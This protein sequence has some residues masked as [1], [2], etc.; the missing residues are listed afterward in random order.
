MK[1]NITLSMYSRYCVV[2]IV[3]YVLDHELSISGFGYDY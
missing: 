1:G 2:T 3:G